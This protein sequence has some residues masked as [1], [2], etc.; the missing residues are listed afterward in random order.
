MFFHAVLYTNNTFQVMEEEPPAWEAGPSGGQRQVPRSGRAPEAQLWGYFV[1]LEKLETTLR[2]VKGRE[3]P[4]AVQPSGPEIHLTQNFERCLKRFAD[5]FPPDLPLGLRTMRMTGH[6][7]ESEGGSKTPMLA[8]CACIE[9]VETLSARQPSA[10][11]YGQCSSE[12][13]ENCAKLK[14][15]WVAYF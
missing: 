10:R 6:A 5:V 4:T 3:I 14:V 2:T 12:I 8:L 15:R 7:I 9:E 11:L 1:W 13:L